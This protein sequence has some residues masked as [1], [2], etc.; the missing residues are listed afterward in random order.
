MSWKDLLAPQGT[1]ERVL[2]WVGGAEVQSLRQAWQIK[3][4]RPPEFG[5]F[6][7]GLS[8][9]QARLLSREPQE[10]NP[11]FEQ[12]TILK[13]Y[14][15]GDR[16]VPDGAS[17]VADPDQLV[18]QTVPVYCVEVGLERFAR[19]SVVRLLDRKLV[20][21]RQEWP[22]AADQAVQ[23]AYQDRKDSVTKLPGV[24][25]ALDLAFR[26]VSRQR[27]QMEERAREL[28]RLRLAEEAKRVAEE[29][30]QELLKT[31]GSAV[32][33][34][35]LAKHDFPAAARAALALSNAELL[36]VRET[37]NR[38]EM[39]V[40]YR[41]KNRRLECTCDRLTLRI[42]DAGVCLDDHRGTKGDTR[43]TLE[44]LPTVI[45]EAMDL[46][47][48]VVWR[49]APGDLGEQRRWDDDPDEERDED[50]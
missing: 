1:D 46:G 35:E 45:Q 22:E 33:R 19:V 12:G 23:E 10:L 4:A 18:A 28:E 9:R 38:N 20:F 50:W 16:F 13:G 27:L 5:W 30:R 41:Y 14:L 21:L 48:L 31:V 34:R 43:F 11:E 39:V 17:V 29:K 49:H 47:K 3:G 7:F 15:I 37:R 26:F 32:G 6:K 42:I 2:P 36:D 25:P 40:Q 8:G 44:S 24:T